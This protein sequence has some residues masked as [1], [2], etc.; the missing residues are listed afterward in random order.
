M[1]VLIAGNGGREH[2]LLWKLKRDAPSGTRFFVTRPNGGMVDADPVPIASTDVPA[3]VAW[4]EDNQLDLVVIG[5]EGPLD[6]GLADRLREKGIPTFG[7]DAGAARIESSKAFAKDLMKAAGVPTAEYRS[8]TDPKPAREHILERGAPIVVK[9]SG[10]AAG[11][12]AIVCGST[13]E[14]LAAAEAMLAGGLAGDAGRE[15]V[16]EEFMVGEELSIFAI[17]DGERSY[18]LSPSQD[19]KRV[20]VGDRGPNTGGMGAY[21]PVSIATPQLVEETRERIL[22]PT[23]AALAE[24]GSPFRGLLYAGLMLTEEG[25]KVVEFNCRFGDPETQV[26][27]PLMAGSLLDPLV[28]VAEGGT[29]EDGV[30][31]VRDGSCVTTVVAASGYPGPVAKG[32]EIAIDAPPSGD[33]STFFFHAGTS[34]ENG[35]IVTSGGRVIAATAAAP[36]LGGAAEASRRAAERVRFEGAFFRPDIGWREERRQER[37]G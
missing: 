19:H 11:K 25:P 26:V 13:D 37:S 24:R 16:V 7:P 30:A 1:R 27:L 10:L 15:V 18:V 20:G 6:A 5:P 17:T 34:K 12:G 22:R 36:T 33:E 31:P 3:L 35:R 28:A 9:A 23:L 14:A 2:A 32:R 29:V 21:A 4:A 8:F